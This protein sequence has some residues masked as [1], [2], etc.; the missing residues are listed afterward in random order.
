VTPAITTLLGIDASMLEALCQN[1]DALAVLC[2]DPRVQELM[3]KD[4]TVVA[5]ERN[6]AII[7]T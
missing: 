6:D 1:K 2:R 3:Q 7:N 4:V 5:S